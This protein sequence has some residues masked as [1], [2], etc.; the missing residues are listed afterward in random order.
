MTETLEEMKVRHKKEIKSFEG[1]KLAACQV[2]G[3]KSKTA[4][5][6]SEFKYEALQRDLMER[7]R[8]ETDQLTNKEEG[9]NINISSGQGETTVDEDKKT[10]VAKVSSDE[11]SSFSSVG[12]TSVRVQNCANIV[13]ILMSYVGGH[14][15][16]TV[17]HQD[18][19]TL[20]RILP[21]RW[22]TP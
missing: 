19:F 21:M 5:K 9:C 4:I 20:L 17:V 22:S 6:E 16:A 13:E 7:H 3:Q 14:F 18:S 15:K 8:A 11:S 2:Q 10:N 12:E 1:E